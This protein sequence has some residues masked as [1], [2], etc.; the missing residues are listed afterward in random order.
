MS[1]SYNQYFD[2]FQE[3][4]KEYG[5]KC[6]VL[7]EFGAFFEIYELNNNDEKIG[8][9]KILSE[10]LRLEYAN[11]KGDTSNNNRSFPNFIGFT[12]SQAFKYFPILLNNGYTIIEVRQ[13][14]TPDIARADGRKNL[15]RGITKIHSPSLYSP[16]F[17][18]F[19]RKSDSNLLHILC[20][21]D[22]PAKCTRKYTIY[23]SICCINNITNDIE[24]TEIHK[25]FILLELEFSELEKVLYR[26]Q[27]SEIQIKIINDTKIENGIVEKINK[28]FKNYSDL[29]YENVDLVDLNSN[30]YKMY[31][32]L[33]F[34]NEY[35]KEIYKHLNFGLLN[36]IEYLGLEKMKT[37]ILNLMY[38]IDFIGKHSLDYTKNLNKPNINNESNNLI[39]ELNTINQLNIF[40]NKNNDTKIK[41][42]SVFDVVNFTSTTIGK[43]KLQSLL[44][45]PFK[46]IKDINFHYDLTE[47]INN[48]CK[49][50][51]ITNLLDEIID[52]E[53]LHRKM[54]LDL[55]HPNEL[56][57]LN[58]T[59]NSIKSLN[60][61]ISNYPNIKLNLPKFE[62]NEYIET[63]NKTFNMD[64]VKNYTLNTTKDEIQNYFNTGVIEDLDIIQ[65]K[66]I[67]L[68]ESRLVLRKS[69]DDLINTSNS[70]NNHHHHHTEFIKLSYSEQEGYSFECT[71]IRYQALLIKLKEF[72]NK[73]KV[74]L[75]PL[76]QELE[77]P[78]RV[79]HMN[80]KTKFFTE[81]LDK[82]SNEILSNRNLLLERLKSN[83]IRILKE[84]Y[85][86]YNEVLFNSLKVFIEYIDICK[87][88]LKCSKKYNYCRP[89]ISECQTSF[90]KAKNLRHPIIERIID[91]E[92]IP[93]DI[94]LSN[95]STGI[96]LY[97]LNSCGKSSILRA[98]GICTILAQCGLY[99]P[100][101][102]FEFYPFN[103]M[104]SQVDMSDDLF[105]GKSSFISEMVGLKKILSCSGPNTLCLSDELCKGTEIYSA[106]G[107]VGSTI[108]Q[109]LSN[110]T[111]FFF[112]THL[113]QIK[114]LDFD[115]NNLK[116]CHLS[117]EIKN[118]N[119]I[120]ERK[121]KEGS[122]SD[123]YGL[124]VAKSILKDNN[125]FDIAFE[126]RKKFTGEKNKIVSL[127]KSKYNT[128][129]ILNKCEI[130]GNEKNLET[131]HINEQQN[132]NE[133]G[134][135]KNKYFHKNEN[136]NL[137][138][139]CKECH[140]KKTLGKIII[141]GYRDS[142]NGRFL[143]WDEIN[144]RPANT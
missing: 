33:E 83:Y 121:L 43:R 55:L 91:T 88:N 90:I 25:S 17:D 100:C 101:E 59:Y 4:Q 95:S 142:I 93:N 1:E 108:K 126:Y 12:T 134:F 76:S 114:E 57:K 119:I 56:Y 77:I 112:T 39:L 79:K 29:E 116:I 54:G 2:I 125:F 27:F 131:D 117:V 133:N 66:I 53:K 128:K 18:D 120:F 78:Q 124:E 80:N 144:P 89:K 61:L 48:S 32:K 47:E 129:K 19:L 84:L 40:D 65:D 13:L 37:S 107:I 67:K 7:M 63:I 11:K 20:Y 111:K 5:E 38:A 23:Y 6:T 31:K 109:L 87:S 58:G 72:N 122:G 26:Y 94:E 14:E 41:Y 141:N 137:A 52:F 123:L 135:I 105:N 49:I 140:L 138:C 21:I 136:F 104:I 139:L 3:K 86:K 24:L 118:D 75:V 9:A 70:K 8:N 51:E 44:S 15:K 10:I 30:E 127:K 99:V 132:T 130:C 110:K 34:Q 68:E 106:I 102:S 113:H 42:K 50:V 62:L 73:I 16:D 92:Y 98:I 64:I 97:A 143:D 82:L 35:F 81:K 28:F 36:P 45:K 96:L 115:D 71:K 69:Y 74:G 46:N 22:G 103:N 85:L 60:V